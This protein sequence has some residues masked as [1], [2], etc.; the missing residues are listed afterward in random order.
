M[1]DG[2][3]ECRSEKVDVLVGKVYD[4]CESGGV[5]S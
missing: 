2:N 4:T 3:A 5:I 1:T